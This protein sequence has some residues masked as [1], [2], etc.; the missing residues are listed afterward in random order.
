[1]VALPPSLP[2]NC[3]QA[4]GVAKNIKLRP[5]EIVLPARSIMDIGVQQSAGNFQTYENVSVFG[6][7]P[8]DPTASSLSD[9]PSND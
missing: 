8:I 5:N 2:S 6:G 3:V 9:L 7:S 1:M 4:I